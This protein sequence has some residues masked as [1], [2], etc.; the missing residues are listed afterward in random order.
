MPRRKK[1]DGMKK[2]TRAIL[3]GIAPGKFENF[4]MTD[5]RGV[6]TARAIASQTSRLMGGRWSVKADYD[7]KI[8]TILRK[9]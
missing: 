4:P 1:Y 9:S 7:N 6:Q 3:L 5:E 8:V 2:P